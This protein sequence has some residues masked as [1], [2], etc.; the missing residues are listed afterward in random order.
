MKKTTYSEVATLAEALRVQQ[1]MLHPTQWRTRVWE[2]LG[3]HWCIEHIPSNG[4]LSLYPSLAG[5]YFAMLSTT[6]AGC[7]DCRWSDNSVYKD[8]QIAVTDMIKTAKT[9]LAKERKAIAAAIQAV[10]ELTPKGEGK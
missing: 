8:P 3:W 9:V 1:L 10:D 6:H 5:G 2:N 4:L 7:G